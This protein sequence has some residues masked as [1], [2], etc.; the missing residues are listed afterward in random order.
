[1]SI[2]SSENIFMNPLLIPMTFHGGKVAFEDSQIICGLF[3]IQIR[4][5][6]N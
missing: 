4:L 3:Y 1:M 2:F 5:Y 6:I